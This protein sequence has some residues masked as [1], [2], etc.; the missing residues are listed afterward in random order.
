VEKNESRGEL[1]KGFRVLSDC[2]GERDRVC[3]KPRGK[4]SRGFRK[5]LR[6]EGK[7]VGSYIKA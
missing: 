4:S 2:C 5:G 7:A 3:E 6:M 1:V